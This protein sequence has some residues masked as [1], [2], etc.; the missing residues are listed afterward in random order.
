MLI[1]CYLPMLG[2]QIAFKEYRFDLGIWGSKWVGLKYFK[3]FVTDPYILPVLRNT[4][5]LS[6]L[7]LGIMIPAPLIF[8][9]MLDEVRSLSG[10]RVFQTISYFPYFISWPVV[11]VIAN[12]WLSPSGFINEILIT[13][14]IIKE[15]YFFLGEPD[16]FWVTMGGLELWKNLGWAAIIYLSA[17]AGINPE[18][19]EAADMDGVGRLKK[20]WY[21][22]IPSIL[23]TVMIMVILNLG[24]MLKGG[25]FSSNFQQCYLFGNPLNKSTADILDTYIFRL[26]ISLGRFSYASAVGLLTGVVSLLLLFSADYS[27]K[28]I[29]GESLL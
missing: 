26:G 7:K 27:S 16:T 18:L 12:G 20:I 3:E 21:I 25:L 9:I 24:N 11:L 23:P 17:I 4:F 1:F 19:Y 5:G 14:R 6:L 28:K 8:A 29:T 15:P 10:K 2:L 22:T 13:F